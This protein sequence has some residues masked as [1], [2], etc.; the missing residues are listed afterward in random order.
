MKKILILL[1]SVLFIGGCSKDEFYEQIPIVKQELQITNKVGI[2]L[3]T[4]FVVDEVSMNVKLEN[5]GT[6]TIRIMDISNKV[7]SKEQINV[8]SG[9][10]ILKVYTSTLPPSAYRIGLYDSNN[11]MLGITDFNKIN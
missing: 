9:D 10:N 7:V 5:S 2:K 11:N 4:S 1:T 3:E 8:K 6:V